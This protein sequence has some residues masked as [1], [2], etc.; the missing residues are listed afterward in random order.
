MNRNLLFF[1]SLIAFFSFINPKDSQAQKYTHWSSGQFYFDDSSRQVVMKMNCAIE[2]CESKINNIL[3]TWNLLADSVVTTQVS[4]NTYVVFLSKFYAISRLE[5]I[6]SRLRTDTSVIYFSPTYYKNKKPICSPTFEIIV[7]LKPNETL[8]SLNDDLSYYNLTLARI[9]PYDSSTIILLGNKYTDVI[10]VTNSM[11]QS[12]KY[13][14]CIPNWIILA[15]LASNPVNDEFFSSQWGLHE[16]GTNGI[17]G[18]T[19]VV[20][21]WNY[22]MG[23]SNIKIALLDNGVDINHEDL[24]ANFLPG[25]NFVDDNTDVSFGRGELHGTMCA[26]VIAAKSNNLVGI[27][28]VAPNCKIIPIKVFDRL[29]FTAVEKLALSIDYAWN[30]KQADIINGSWG[31]NDGVQPQPIADAITRAT[32]F[33]RGG[34]GTVVIF[35]SGNNNLN[36]VDFPANFPLAIGVGSSTQCNSR[37]TTNPVSCDGITSVEGSN[38]GVGLDLVAPGASVTTTDIT[39][40]IGYNGL[41]NNNYTSFSGTSAAAPHV[42]GVVA[43]MLSMNNNL[44]LSQVKHH[45]FSTASKVGGYNYQVGSGDLNYSWNQEMGYGKVDA[46]YAVASILTTLGVEARYTASYNPRNPPNTILR[47]SEA[48][49]NYFYSAP[50]CCL[51]V[52]TITGG[53]TNP[54]YANWTGSWV[55]DPGNPYVHVV[56]NNGNT[57]QILYDQLEWPSQYFTF[58]L[59]YTLT[60]PCGQTIRAVYCFKNA[61]AEP[62]QSSFKGTIPRFEQK[63]NQPRLFPTVIN[64]NTDFN[65]ELPQ[66]DN[67]ELQHDISI[68][69]LKGVLIRRQNLM[70]KSGTIKISS[71][72]LSTGMYIVRLHSNGKPTT[73]KLIVQ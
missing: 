64:R 8:S 57:I 10:N 2:S 4:G 12:N 70:M 1:L 37:K 73:F 23:C 31:F 69:D 49:F 6:S 3:Q 63:L 32:S 20:G 55:I 56:S 34:K 15:T 26:G 27:S 71:N 44:T 5:L 52:L 61:V 50:R 43:L 67:D 46:S 72:G 33:G 41:T 48:W 38:W 28:G 21:A 30:D 35:A 51:E 18:G 9:N 16:P 25:Y 22:S 11:H 13:S 7:K 14:Y 66:S 39:G 36:Q 60:G 45:L 42:A 62:F 40:S 29:V 65:I 47:E 17:N 19:N 24:A 59:R 68:F 54:D 53:T 58:K